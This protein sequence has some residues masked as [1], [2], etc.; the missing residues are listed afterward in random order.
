MSPVCSPQVM[1]MMME[2][3]R[4]VAGLFTAGNNDD[5]D[6]HDDDD[7]D[8]YHHNNTCGIDND[9]NKRFRCFFLCRATTQRRFSV[10]QTIS[11]RRWVLQPCRRNSGINPCWRSQKMAAMSSATRQP[12]IS[13]MG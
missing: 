10:W 2:S 12:G 6:D 7:D 11:S 8:D 4:S 3:H 9:Y 5:D 13:T 1:M